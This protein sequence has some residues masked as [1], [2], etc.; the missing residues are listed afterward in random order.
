M[1]IILINPLYPIR[2]CEMTNCHYNK[3]MYVF[4]LSTNMSYCT[5][6]T[7]FSARYF[8]RLVSNVYVFSMRSAGMRFHAQQWRCH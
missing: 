2:L 6:S 4:T 5:I 1:D 3:K 7:D 8:D